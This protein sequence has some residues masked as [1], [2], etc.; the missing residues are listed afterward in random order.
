M[1]KLEN[2][3]ITEYIKDFDDNLKVNLEIKTSFHDEICEMITFEKYP[4]LYFGTKYYFEKE[5]KKLINIGIF[6]NTFNLYRNS[7]DSILFRLSFRDN[8]INYCS[9]FI[10]D[11]QYFLIT[12]LKENDNFYLEY[13]GESKNFEKFGKGIEYYHNNNIK[14]DGEFKWNIPHGT[15]SLYDIGG[16]L[17]FTGNFLDGAPALD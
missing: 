2:F 11:S 4:G 7:K 6:N 9:V 5:E 10:K 3:N 13:K 15:G 1:N 14:Y 12:F 8:R 17:I 16:G